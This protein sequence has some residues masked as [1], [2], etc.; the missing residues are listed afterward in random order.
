MG[1]QPE[2]IKDPIP[3]PETTHLGDFS[4]SL[5]EVQKQPGKTG[6]A[7]YK[8][9]IPPK[10][11]SKWHDDVVFGPEWRQLL[12]DFDDRFPAFTL[13]DCLQFLEKVKSSFP[14]VCYVGYD[15]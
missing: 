4:F 2:Y 9:T 3:L 12:K 15:R 13:K 6:W 11:R 7:S 1:D 8:I 5:V 14:Q 10:A